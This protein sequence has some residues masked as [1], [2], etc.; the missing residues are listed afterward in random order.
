[1]YLGH[2][3]FHQAL[4]KYIQ[5]WAFKH[6]TPYDFFY[7]MEQEAGEEL[8]WF[9]R[10]WFFELNYPDLAI[11][12]KGEDLVISNP[13]GLPLPVDVVIVTDDAEKIRRYEASVWKDKHEIRI[14]VS[15][16]K[17]FQSAYL[18]VKA[19]PDSN[20]QNNKVE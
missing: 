4:R 6:P 12:R 13:G 2:E 17:T 16:Y 5:E 1:N 7:L 14:P 11:E 10:P 19:I 9:W 8:G 20:A 15:D 3:V 18:D